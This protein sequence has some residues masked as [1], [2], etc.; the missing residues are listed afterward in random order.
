MSR[1]WLGLILIVLVWAAAAWPVQVVR[2]QYGVE[3]TIY[4]PVFD[5]NSPWALYESA[6][7]AGDVLIAKNTKAAVATTNNAVDRGKTHSVTLTATEMAA[8]DIGLL[9]QDQTS[10]AVFGD[11]MI[12]V[13]TWGDPNS[14]YPIVFDANYPGVQM[15]ETRK[16]NN[17][18]DTVDPNLLPYELDVK[19]DGSVAIDGWAAFLLLVGTPAVSL[20]DNVND[21]S[22]RVDAIDAATDPNEVWTRTMPAS[23]AAGTFAWYIKRILALVGILD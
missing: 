1:K 10:P 18:T 17:G 6:L 22:G 9:V 2:R 11:N 8:K 23:P 3:T 4:F 12:L 7:A 13:E 16:V 5:S 15:T 14:G 21:V 20:A 19:S